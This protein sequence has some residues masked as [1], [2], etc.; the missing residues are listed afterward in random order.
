MNY[1]LI[2]KQEL[3]E[4][5]PKSPCCRKAY[6]AGLF[7]D[8]LEIGASCLA[9]APTAAAARR[10][11]A[12]AYREHYR[13][14]ALLSNGAMLFSSERLYAARAEKPVFAC[15]A[16]VGH[17]LRG[18]MIICGSITDPEKA[19][20]LEFRLANSAKIPFL[21]ELLLEWG[22]SF[23]CRKIRGGLGLYTKNSTVIEELLTMMGA[24]NALFTMMNAKIAREIRNVEN[25]ATNCVAQNIRRSVN[26][27][28]KQ[29]EAITAIMD[30][31]CFEK[32]PLELQET[33]ELRLHHPDAT[34]AELASLHNPPITKSGLNHR[35]QKIME[36]AKGKQ[37][38][39]PLR[40]N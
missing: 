28:T 38:E 12:R 15:S 8:A 22:W 9:L 23:Q 6:V 18:V 2:L 33:A 37:I 36:Y 10:E 1:S 27:A 7:F 3:I 21:S 24:N 20:H 5:A 32:M 25:R 4:G 11:C 30:A 13:R 16:C 14:E 35:L 31:S 34:L 40:K 19:Y 26:A 39:M 17:F 29:C